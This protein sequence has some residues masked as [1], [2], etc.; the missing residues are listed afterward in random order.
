[1]G[2]KKSTPPA[3]TPTPQ[4]QTPDVDVAQVA[5]EKALAA[6]GNLNAQASQMEPKKKKEGLGGTG[7][8]PMKDPASMANA[9]APGTMASSAILTG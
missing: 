5:A 8:K 3:A 1:M 2:G 7:P 9:T 6:Q 4:V